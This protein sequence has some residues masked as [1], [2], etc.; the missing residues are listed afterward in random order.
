MTTTFVDTTTICPICIESIGTAPPLSKCG[1]RL[2]RQCLEKHFR[3]E[4][5]VCRTPQTDVQ[6]RG[7]RPRP[8]VEEEDIVEIPEVSPSDTLVDLENFPMTHEYSEEDK[9]FIQEILSRYLRR[10]DVSPDEVYAVKVAMCRATTG[11]PNLTSLS[12]E[13]SDAS[14][15]S[16]GDED[17]YS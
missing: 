17:S 7:A 4:C 2:H 6:V 3:Q 11:N 5:P 10:E 8:S 13:E 12:D 16:D 1:H 9:E 15:S 14:S